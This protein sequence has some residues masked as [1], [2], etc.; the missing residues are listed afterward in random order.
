MPTR[1]RIA[2]RGAQGL[3]ADLLVAVLWGVD[4]ALMSELM[5]EPVRTFT[6]A[7]KHEEKYNELEYARQVAKR[8][9]TEHQEVVLE[10]HDLE[11]FLPKLIYY[12]DE[13]LADWVCVP[14]HF[15]AKLARQNRT[16]VARSARA[17]T[18]CSTAIRITFA[19]PV[20]AVNSGSP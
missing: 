8:Y 11:S 20:S 13:P 9:G 1:P 17:Q 2:G 16:V 4:G 15:L 14:L 12:Q 6:V 7:F 19:T 5:T 3:C 18:S 10:A